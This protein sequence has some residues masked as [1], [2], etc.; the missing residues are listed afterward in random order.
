MTDSRDPR[1]KGMCAERSGFLF[2]HECTRMSSGNCTRCTKEICAE[3]TFASEEGLLCT[4]CAKK[5][6]RQQRAGMSSDRHRH[7][8]FFYHGYYHGWGHYGHGHWGHHHY[9]DENDLTEADGESL[10]A[11][12]D[13]D[14]EQD[15]GGS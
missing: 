10:Q 9:R 1:H 12:A 8:P 11:E 4:T 3:H 5:A 15:M 2:S 6:R 13:E 7:D 14:F